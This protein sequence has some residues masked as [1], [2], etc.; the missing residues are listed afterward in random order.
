MF[1][2]NVCSKMLVNHELYKWV[3]SIIDLP[4]LHQYFQAN[5]RNTLKQCRKKYSKRRVIVITYNLKRKSN[6]TLVLKYNRIKIHGGFG[7]GRRRPLKKVW[8]FY[9]QLILHRQPQNRVQKVAKIKPNR[10]KRKDEKRKE[11][12]PKE[13]K[14]KVEKAKVKSPPP[15]ER[16]EP[17]NDNSDGYEFVYY[18]S[19]DEETADI[20]I[21]NSSDISPPVVTTANEP[22]V[23]EISSSNDISPAT[24]DVEIGEVRSNSNPAGDAS[25]KGAN[26]V[27]SVEADSSNT[28]D[29]NGGIE[30]NDISTCT[31]YSNEST[32]EASDVCDR[33]RQQ[34][35]LLKK[36]KKDGSRLTPGISERLSISR[37]TSINNLSTSSRPV[38]VTDDEN[39]KSKELSP[40]VTQNKV[41]AKQLPPPP[42]ARTMQCS[43][44]ANRSVGFID[45]LI[46]KLYS[47]GTAVSVDER[48]RALRQRR[49]SV[50]PT[51]S[52]HLNKSK[53]R[54]RSAPKKGPNT[55]K[56]SN[57][58]TARSKSFIA[59]RNSC[60][61]PEFYGFDSMKVNDAP[62]LLPTPR[63]QKPTDKQ[64]VFVS[65]ELDTFM[66]ENDLDNV[67]TV[68][69][70]EA[71]QT[72]DEA[73][74]TENAEPPAM[75][76]PHRP[77]SM[78]RPRT[79][80]EKRILYEKRKD[81]K[82]LMIE[83]ESSVY[84]EL[85]K[86]EKDGRN[87]DNSLLKGMLDGN[88]PFTRDCWRATCWLNTDLN[89]F[90]FQTIQYGDQEI[91]VFSG[92]GNNKFKLL[93]A[94][95]TDDKHKKDAKFKIRKLKSIRCTRLCRAMDKIKIN[96]IDEYCRNLNRKIKTDPE[97]VE[98]NIEPMRKLNMITNVSRPY[99]K[100][101]PLCSKIAAKRTSVD[102]EYGPYQSYEMPTVQLEVWPRLEQPLPEQIQPYLKL[103]LPH[104]HITDQWAKFAV[105]A[106]KTQ[107][108]KRN[109]RKFKRPEDEDLGSFIFDIPYENNQKKMLVRRRRMHNHWE[110]L[111][112][113]DNYAYRF[114]KDL[115][116]TD[117]VA[118]E[119]ADVLSQ[120]I[121][122]VAITANE[123]QF[124]DQDPDI[125]Y[126][127]K[128]VPIG[129]Y[130]KLKSRARPKVSP[131]NEGS[132]STQQNKVM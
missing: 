104:D 21:I 24:D 65:E 127:G 47:T 2:L 79:L 73:L 100:P 29:R 121:T 32:M 70:P 99:V 72:Y 52:S 27:A 67:A 13:E 56:T 43:S 49:M 57:D 96:N 102:V 60:S 22:I 95:N 41:I 77:D 82:F 51:E 109:S 98:P 23:A 31:Q 7:R 85:K 42:S 106:V 8:N 126:I 101:G 110:P 111:P 130:M 93:Y 61:S 97:I 11:E 132:K 15:I 28:V 25:G 59:R 81:F 122:S 76:V 16:D 5:F 123:N 103:I 107:T 18:Q 3:S 48:L 17:A 108:R 118:I 66:K 80:A 9:G 30:T 75:Q 19:S 68:S 36:G 74:L 92:R 62:G 38:N 90:F 1:T 87:F 116:H 113:D 64:S 91:K 54:P 4:F 46:N 35:E 44:T 120:M 125:D 86:R 84:H 26:D 128:I 33:L 34:L 83:N 55:N 10:T 88:S 89:R 40:P 71:R 114:S 50:V 39:S 14:P 94:L 58:T 12:K 119:C 37:R 112:L 45:T 131:G 115:D 20:G 69:I 117:T 63:V 124:I 53:E 78:S 105:C 129:N 6:K